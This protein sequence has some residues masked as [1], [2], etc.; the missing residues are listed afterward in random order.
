[1]L[2]TESKIPKYC[3]VSDEIPKTKQIYEQEYFAQY[4][5]ICLKAH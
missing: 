4:T 1:M 2:E 3:S 5:Y